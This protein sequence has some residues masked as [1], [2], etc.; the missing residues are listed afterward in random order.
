MDLPRAPTIGTHSFGVTDMHAVLF[1]PALA[2]RGRPEPT[3]VAVSGLLGKLILALTDQR[4]RPADVRR[5][6][7]GGDDSTSWTEAPEQSLRLPEPRDDRLQ[8]A[9]CHVAGRSRE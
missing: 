7:G 1:E 6:D 3:V 5:R 8:G 2:Q 4:I 9:D